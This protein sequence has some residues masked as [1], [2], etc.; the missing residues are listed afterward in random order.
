MELQ[1]GKD[2]PSSMGAKVHDEKGKPIGLMI[3]MTKP[4]HRRKVITIDS[5]FSVTCSIIAMKDRG[6]DEAQVR[7]HC[8]KDDG[9]VTKIMSCFG[10]PSEV[11]NHQTRQVVDGETYIF[12]Y[13]EAVLIHNKTKHALDDMNKR[14]HDSVSL[15][16][17]W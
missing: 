11:D 5:G 14:C 16:D 9:Y 1:E 2:Q 15:A 10:M 4:I 3:W 6:V 8:Q 12:K 17:R 13:P 7:V